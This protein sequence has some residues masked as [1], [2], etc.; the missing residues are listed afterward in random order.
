MKTRALGLTKTKG[1]TTLE[2][3]WDVRNPDLE[4]AEHAV[5]GVCDKTQI[6]AGF[7]NHAELKENTKKRWKNYAQA[8]FDGPIGGMP[9][10][11]KN[12]NGREGTFFM[13]GGGP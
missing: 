6:S 11:V 3:Q 9:S 2:F 7:Y 4:P 13:K 10:W 1:K 8:R 5:G 12:N